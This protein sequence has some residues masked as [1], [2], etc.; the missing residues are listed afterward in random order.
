MAANVVNKAYLLKEK[1][2]SPLIESY[3]LMY[4]LYLS[5]MGL[6]TYQS[7][8]NAKSFVLDKDNAFSG[9]YYENYLSIE[10][11]ARGYGLFY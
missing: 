6:F 8:L 2:T 4:R 5:D 11:S 9:I 1:V 10:L 3:D 7:G